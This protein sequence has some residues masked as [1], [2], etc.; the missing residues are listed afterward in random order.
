MIQASLPLIVAVV[1]LYSG[2][3]EPP[4]P[5][6]PR[7]ILFLGS[8]LGPA[9]L[10]AV[11]A[12]IA[13]RRI[14]RD[15]E[16]RP[17]WLSRTRRVAGVAEGGVMVAF[18]VGAWALPLGG[19]M[20]ALFGWIPWA[21]TRRLPALV[22]LVG[23]LLLTRLAVYE[24]QRQQEAAYGPFAAFQLKLWALSLMPM[25]LYLVGSDLFVHA[26]LGLRLFVASYPVLPYLGFFLAVVFIST[27]A[28]AW[29]RWFWKTE[30]FEHPTLRERLRDVAAR[31]GIAYRQ[32]SVWF[33]RGLR[34]ANAAVAGLLP[35]SREI[36]VTDWLLQR[37]DEDQIEGV[38]LH[39]L[40]H[41]R[42][43]HIFYYLLFSFC[44]F[45]FYLLGLGGI[46]RWIPPFFREAF[47]GPVLL[48]SAFIYIYFVL[49]FGFIS[50]QFERQADYF[51]VRHM[52]KPSA[53]VR[54]LE[55]LA[56]LHSLSTRFR[57]LFE[58]TKTHPSLLRRIAFAQ[59]AA[60]ND[61]A[62]E[63][64]AKTLWV[65]KVLVLLVPVTVVG[66]GVHREGLFG[67]RGA[68]HRER[69]VLLLEEVEKLRK[70]H[71]TLPWEAP[72]AQAL[73]R[74]ATN[75][76]GQAREELEKALAV[77]PKTSELLYL[78]GLTGMYGNQ[79][80]LAE[81]AFREALALEPFHA[82]SLYAL[83]RLY[84]DRQDWTQARHYLEMA[85]VAAP[86]NAQIQELR[87]RIE[88]HW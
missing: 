64:Y 65:A 21:N 43:R 86:G 88:A 72:E 31:Y 36:F 18:L 44:Y 41:L 54:M 81:K 4:S 84:A 13:R 59:K 11:T 15:K 58:W 80:E 46:S 71:D 6:Y 25:G 1:A 29:L 10:A 16:S 66:V 55:G 23:A 56:E 26:P 60:Q 40:G 39:E 83:A 63:R 27:N 82:A 20:D 48:V 69:A 24:A 67:S 37:M 68:I 47:W 32:V 74:R 35:R 79:R 2:G 38:L 62:L 75:L 78:Y 57:Q 51:A 12:A 53:Y 76:N 14:Q 33:T 70:P 61:P 8:L 3:G 9:A 73:R 30:P 77:E 17:S 49:L 87:R 52:Q 19:M 85:E 22:P 28:P 42:H 7:L 5:I 45:G 34:I 50:R